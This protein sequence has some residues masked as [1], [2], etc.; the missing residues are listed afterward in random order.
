MT[1]GPYT[2]HL[3][4][5]PHTSTPTS[6]P[7]TKITTLLL[8]P[9]LHCK[10]NAKSITLGFQCENGQYSAAGQAKIAERHAANGGSGGEN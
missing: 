8:S 7:P 9:P 10:M 4:Q 5:E 1:T 6:H 3:G 2:L